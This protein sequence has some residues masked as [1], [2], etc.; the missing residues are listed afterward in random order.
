MAPNLLIFLVY[1]IPSDREYGGN[2]VNMVSTYAMVS[3]SN[4]RKGATIFTI[5][6]S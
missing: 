1:H 3:P 4:E 6:L 2:M 5:F